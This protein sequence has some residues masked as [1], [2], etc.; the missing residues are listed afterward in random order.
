MREC[1]KRSHQNQEQKIFI[2]HV[3]VVV[4]YVWKSKQLRIIVTSKKCRNID[5]PYQ[6]SEVIF[7]DIVHNTV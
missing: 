6:T 3:K 1:Q 5:L 2:K 4:K 7:K